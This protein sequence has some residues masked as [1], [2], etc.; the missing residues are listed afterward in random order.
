MA[1][2]DYNIIIKYLGTSS[3][4]SISPYTAAQR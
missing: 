4:D 3:D 1:L 2:G